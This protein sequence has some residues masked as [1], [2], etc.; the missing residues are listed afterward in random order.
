MVDYHVMSVTVTLKRH[1]SKSDA[2]PTWERYGL[3]LSAHKSIDTEQNTSEL[4]VLTSVF[5]R[6]R[7]ARIHYLRFRIATFRCS[8]VTN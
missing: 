1:Y 2:L 5:K 8:I 7:F 4:E 3:M 6:F